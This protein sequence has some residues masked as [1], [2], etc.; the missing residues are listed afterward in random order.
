MTN[1]MFS[2]EISNLAIGIQPAIVQLILDENRLTRH[3]LSVHNGLSVHHNG[4]NPG[5]GLMLVP[6]VHVM[7]GIHLQRP[8][9]AALGK[10][11]NIV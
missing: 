10:P 3:Y 11:S 7:D 2:L 8:A 9:H 5:L 1:D 4:V 6:H